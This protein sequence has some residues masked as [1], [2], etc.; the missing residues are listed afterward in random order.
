SQRSSSRSQR[1]VTKRVG[2]RSSSCSSCS[3]M[4]LAC[5]ACMPVEAYTKT[6]SP[7]RETASRCSR[8]S[9]ASSS[10]SPF[11]T[12]SRSSKPRAP[13]SS[14]S[15]MRM[16]QSSCAIGESVTEE[17]LGE[18][19]LVEVPGDAAEEERPAGAEQEACVDVCCLRH[20]AFLQQPVDLVRD[21]LEHLFDD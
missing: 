15:S 3:T 4:R 13:S 10:A 21:G 12:P 11:V 17:P 19:D 6:V 18:P 5:S 14:G 7:S 8:S 9:S 16:R 1:S 20:D 2:V